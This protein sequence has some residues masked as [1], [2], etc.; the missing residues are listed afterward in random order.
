M[1]LKSYL[2]IGLLAGAMVAPALGLA[3]AKAPEN[4]DSYLFVYFPSNQDENLY[5]AIGTDGFNFTPL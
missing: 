5:Y 2:K 3:K 1:T 4:Y